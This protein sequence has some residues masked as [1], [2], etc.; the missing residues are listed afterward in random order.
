MMELPFIEKYRAKT[1]DDFIVTTDVETIQ[2]LIKF[3]DKMP[4]LLFYGLQGTGKSTLA[5]IIINYLKPIDVLRINGSDS[6]GVDNIRETVYTFMIS[7]SSIP[8]KPKIVWIEEADFLSQNAWAALR[9]MIEQYMKNTRFI[10]TLNYLNKIPE[11]ILSR[12]TLFEF[13]KPKNI[14]DV[15]QKLQKICDA[16]NIKYDKDSGIFIELLNKYSGDIRSCI[17]HIQKYSKNLCIAST[18]I[19]TRIDLAQQVYNLLTTKQWTRIRYDIC[20]KSP[21]YIDLLIQLDDLFFKDENIPTYKKAEINLI[22]SDGLVD[23]NNSFDKNIW[24][25]A[26]CYKIIKVL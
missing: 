25:S 17:N 19:E 3:P 11:P 26:I 10:I 16:E 2:E 9:S 4:N 5:K 8:G 12:F 7:S 20:S 23:Y 18:D 24:F 22:I 6:T 1:F 13:T 14:E 15:K 21:N